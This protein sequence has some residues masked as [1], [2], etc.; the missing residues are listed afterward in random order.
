MFYVF[1]LNSKSV[2]RIWLQIK[3]TVM[4]TLVVVCFSIKYIAML[5]LDVIGIYQHNP[6]FTMSTIIKRYN[7]DTESRPV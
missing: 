4:T 3:G 1:C 6:A 2:Q 5:T 7:D